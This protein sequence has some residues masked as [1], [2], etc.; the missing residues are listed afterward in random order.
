MKK[1]NTEYNGWAN[2]ETWN[3]MLWINNDK[4]FYDIACESK[5]YQKFIWEMGAMGVEETPD[6][7]SFTDDALDLEEIAEAFEELDA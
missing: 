3:I 2:F 6:G 1:N 4:S 5:T 7:V